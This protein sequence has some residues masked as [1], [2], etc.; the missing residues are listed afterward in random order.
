MTRM[1]AWVAVLFF[2]A[3]C[4]VAGPRPGEPRAP[5]APA[6]GRIPGLEAGAVPDLRVGVLVG[7][8]TARV[9]ATGPVLV[10]DDAGR[11]RGRGRAGDVW[12]ASRSGAGVEARSGTETLR[13]TGSLIF[14]P[15]G[16]GLLRVADRAYR[17]AVL[18]RPADTGVTVVNLLDLE[19]YLMGVVPHEIGAGRPAEELE[20]VKAQAIA[21][22]TYAVRHMGRR[23]NL[24]FDLYAT[25]M[26]QVYGG[27]DAEDATA[28]RAVGETRGE[29]IVHGDGPIEAYY[30]STCGGRTAAIEEVW[31]AD[32]LPYLRSI[33]DERPSGGAYCETSNR[34]RWTERW[35]RASLIETLSRG[36]QERGVM[37]G[38]VTR[39][40][41]ISVT[42]LTPSGRVERLVVATNQGQ[43]RIRGDSIRWILR[44]EPNRILN[45]AAV[46]LEASGHGEVSELVVH[47]QGWGHGIGM[48]QVGALG[49]SRDG[50]SYRDILT[51]YY[52]GTQIVRLYR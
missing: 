8:E 7:V 49:R 32:P 20:A 51:A 50:H 52:P 11:V 31:P 17:G 34:F 27:A 23:A 42:G 47:G 38:P 36:L 10:V 15:T 1:A 43:H 26:D 16:D 33:S 19:T 21:A 13:A 45:S 37:S 35:D 29:I 40:E 18:L 6:D 12:T 2:T 44:P 24:G 48:C 41:H 28:S 5:G 3:G 39:V 30:H 14:R 9:E 4:T 22:R 46:T 25:V